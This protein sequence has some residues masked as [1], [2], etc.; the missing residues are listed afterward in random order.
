MFI[1]PADNVRTFF[2]AVVFLYWAID[3]GTKLNTE[4][5]RKN[6]EDFAAET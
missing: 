4:A 6:P 3:Y 2:L 1:N 5:N